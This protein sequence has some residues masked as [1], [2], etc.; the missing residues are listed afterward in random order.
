[1][2]YSIAMNNEH[3]I[4]I[5]TIGSLGDLNP[6]LAI[7]ERLAALGAHVT[8][9]TSACYEAACRRSGF[10]FMPLGGADDWVR[11]LRYTRD[12]LE[13]GGFESFVERASFDQLD[14]VYEQL[15]AA[16]AD[17]DILVAPSH[18]VAAH[19]VAEK[20]RIP[21]ISCALCL[22]HIKSAAETG[23]EEQKRISLSAARWHSRLRQ[24]RRAHGLERR[25]LPLTSVVLDAKKV[26]G[27]LPGFLLSPVEMR[28]PNLEVVGYAN[29]HQAGRLAQDEELRGF[30]DERTVAFSFGSFADACDPDHFFQESVAACRTLNLKCVY[31]SQH[32]TPA[33]LEGRSQDVM[34]RS[35][36]A[37]GA[38]FPLAG[39]AVHHG[40]TGTLVAA[41]TPIKPMVIVPFF[42]DQPLHARRMN[43]LIGAP[44]IPAQNYS[45][46][47]AV[48]ALQQALLQRESMSSRLRAEMAQYRDG[49]ERS[50]HEIL[51]TL[52]PQAVQQVHC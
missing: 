52:S 17:A 50:A 32:V 48:Q 25:V 14:M 10:R 27:V 29:Y 45:R 42:L 40:G 31:L 24:F 23:T 13:E 5:A 19:L 15:L 44:H 33:M 1:M 22:L 43:S 7:G 39:I 47:S 46:E 2:A 37:P 51:S 4:L 30:C 21:Y 36:V 49:A 3:R 28:T 11:S 16:A 12:M 41:C 18:V 35:D 26:L 38:V 8:F 34:V 20:K 9:A 6:M